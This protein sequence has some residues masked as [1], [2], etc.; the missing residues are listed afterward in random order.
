MDD[1]VHVLRFADAAT[2]EV[3]ARITQSQR[4][5][6]VPYEFLLANARQI[7]VTCES[8]PFTKGWIHVFD[9]PYHASTD[10]SG[11]V[12]LDSIPAGLH[13]VVVWHERFEEQRVQ[14]QVEAGGRGM[15]RVG[16]GGG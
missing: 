15:V 4:G 14:V 12:V 3:L 11:T 9:H 13:T 16:M 5:Q 1:A 7:V 2:G 10:R 6:V 8:H